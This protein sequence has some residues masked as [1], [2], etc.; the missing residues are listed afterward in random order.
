M[1]HYIHKLLRKW[2]TFREKLRFFWFV[3]TTKDTDAKAEWKLVEAAYKKRIA[4]KKQL[5][6]LDP[7]EREQYE[8]IKHSVPKQFQEGLFIAAKTV[9]KQVEEEKQRRDLYDKKQLLDDMMQLLEHYVDT[10]VDLAVKIRT[11]A[12]DANDKLNIENDIKEALKV[13]Y[14]EDYC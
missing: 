5:E 4:I 10:Q 7:K 8:T 11:V 12:P 13:K 9:Q 3:F 14:V 1:K 2:N 6:K